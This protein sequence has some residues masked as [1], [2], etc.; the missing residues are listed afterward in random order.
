MMLCNIQEDLLDE[1]EYLVANIKQLKKDI[2]VCP[3]MA[4]CYRGMIIA[5][6]CEI[7]FLTN[8]YK[9]YFK[10]D[11]DLLDKVLW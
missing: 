2:D 9:R 11:L 1:I 7:C 6:D 3:P 8:L 10:H 4:S 5:Y